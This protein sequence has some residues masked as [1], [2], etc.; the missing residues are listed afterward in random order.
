MDEY[1]RSQQSP[2]GDS[3]LNVGTFVSPP[4]TV[5]Q[6]PRRFTTDSGRVPTLSSITNMRGSENKES[7]MTDYKVQLL[8]K[9]KAEYERIREQKR[10]F[11][12]EMY[13][14]DQQ[15]RDEEK[16]LAR[17]A[18]DLGRFGHQSEPTT[19][20]EYRD[21]I[22]GFPGVFSRPNRYST[23]TLISPPGFFTRPG[24]SGSQLTS[25][26]PG[27]LQ[28]L[29]SSQFAFN[30]Q[31]PSRSVPASRRNSDEDEKEEAVRQDP[32]SHRSTNALNRYSMPVTRS[33][34]Y[35]SE[36]N[37]DSSID[38]NN[39]AGF[40]FGDEDSGNGEK[41]YQA[42]NQ[43]DVYP[44]I[45]NSA[46]GNMLSAT[47]TA[48]D[49]TQGQI[50]AVD[51]TSA[52]GWGSI[53]HHRPQQSLSTLGSAQLANNSSVAS[54]PA[55]EISTIGSRTPRHS[56]ELKGYQVASPGGSD[57]S[58]T[59]AAVSQPTAHHGNIMATPPKLQQSYSANEGLAL[60]SPNGP[61]AM[62]P[63]SANANNHAQ[64]HFH[65]HNL[66][67]GRYP[68]GAQPNNRHSREMSNENNNTAASRE[69][70]S[71]GSI[72]STLH[73]NAP[74]F[75]PINPP[76]VPPGP[77][78]S[79]APNPYQYYQPT[80]P[81]NGA[82]N[83]AAYG[84]PQNGYAALTMGMQGLN[85]NGHGGQPMYPPPQGYQPYN[86]GSGYQGQVARV[87]ERDS[88]AR[89]IQ[90]R[91]AMDNEVMSRFNNMDLESCTG[92][93]YELCKDQHGCRFLQKQLEQRDPHAVHK[94]WLETNQHVTE[95]MID[96]FGNYLCQK[97]LEFCNDEER[98]VLIQNAAQDMVRIALNQHGTRA[99]QKMIEYVSTSHQVEIIVDALRNQVVDLIQDLNGNHVIQKCLNKLSA[100][101]AQFILTPSVT[102]VLRLAL[103]VTG[104]VFCSAALTTPLVNRR[105]G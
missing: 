43:T 68:A 41:S 6:L 54:G 17:L 57:M 78:A 34:S 29:G 25:P 23:S 79:Y 15:Q 48:L 18:V 10:R 19:P 31:L 2:R 101:E 52:N 71:Y 37:I 59:T 33:R 24:R 8:E 39:T 49:S 64:Q 100:P 55:S 93:I 60:K 3:H 13:K 36:L 90:S 56:M 67:S 96:P 94:I 75:G 44:S 30:N 70:S 50:G 14:L 65:N 66:N 87:A 9:K 73:A 21:S 97:L 81:Y 99:L 104:A 4:R 5:P 1:F 98:T 69:T 20:P 40:L 26:P 16:E 12:V 45:R 83:G 61:A 22:N 38:S 58:G 85:V 92:Q 77:A 95:L 63:V 91:R 53:R 84:G 82:V 86:N 46:Y 27:L 28:S 103:I 105:P 32:T 88:Q 76:T 80:A 35:I 47:S 72:N 51:N 7:H 102:T 42:A 62:P 74:T 11:E 89:V